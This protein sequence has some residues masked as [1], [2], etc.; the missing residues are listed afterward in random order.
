VSGGQRCVL[1]LIAGRVQG[2]GYRAWTAARAGELGLSGFV[3]NRRSGAVEAQF[4]G[5]AGAVAAMLEKCRSGPP[6]AMVTGVDIVA[7]GVAE[8]VG[9]EIRPT[10]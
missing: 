5:E 3:R 1:V 6:G 10:V 2:V 4:S 9:F 8:A 7:E